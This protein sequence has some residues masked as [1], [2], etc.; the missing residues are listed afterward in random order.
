MERVNVGRPLSLYAATVPVA[1]QSLTGTAVTGN[2]TSGF[3]VWVLNVTIAVASDVGD[4]LD[5]YVDTSVDGTVWV[6]VVHFAQILG[7]GTAKRFLAIVSPASTVM[8]APVD[9]SADAAAGAVRH[10]LGHQ[11]RYRLVQVDADSDAN[12]AVTLNGYLY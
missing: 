12:F 6:N 1:A 8:T 5:V 2:Y 10:A 7:N 4:T 3:A 9:V 11:W